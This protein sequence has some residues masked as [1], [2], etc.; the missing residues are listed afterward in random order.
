T[1][2]AILSPA[3]RT[4]S[5]FPLPDTAVAAASECSVR[6]TE[7]SKSVGSEAQ[8]GTAA[9]TA[10]QGPNNR[11]GADYFP[12]LP[13]IHQKRRMLNFYDDVIKGKI[14]VISFIYELPGS[15]SAHHCENGAAG[16]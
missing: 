14:V 3:L 1:A 6:A 10:S 2:V 16:R 11:W 15:L 4:Q 7:G 9:Q 12:N 8:S 5:L 13:V